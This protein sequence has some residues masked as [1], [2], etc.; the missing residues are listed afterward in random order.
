M[1]AETMWIAELETRHT[2]SRGFGKTPEE[3]VASLVALWRDEWAKQSGADPDY[4]SDCRDDLTV[5]PFEP[6]KAYL[7][8]TGDDLW[9]KNLLTGSDPRFDDI[10]APSGLK[11]SR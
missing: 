1:S 7:I 6:G 2:N 8:G 3:A 9:H 10:L 5:S 11:P 4:L